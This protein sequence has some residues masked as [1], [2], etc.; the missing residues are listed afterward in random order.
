MV[1]EDPSL[2]HPECFPIMIPP[3]DP[4]YSQYDQHCMEFTRSSP[5][6]RCYLGMICL[7]SQVV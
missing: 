2:K 6:A 7:I 3:D 1:K 5:A 4:F